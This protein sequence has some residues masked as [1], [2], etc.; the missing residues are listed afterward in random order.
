VDLT[1]IRGRRSSDLTETKEEAMGRKFLASAAIAAATFGVTAGPAL[2]NSVGPSFS[3]GSKLSAQQHSLVNTRM[4]AATTASPAAGS[5]FVVNH[6]KLSEC[7]VPQGGGNYVNFFTKDTTNY[8]EFSDLVLV[9]SCTADLNNKQTSATAGDK[10]D[11]KKLIPFPGTY[12][13][14]SE[15]CNI[16]YK[17]ISFVGDALSVVYPSGQFIETC[18]AP[19][20]L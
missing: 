8:V 15:A 2:A 5:A 3:N 9:G 6:G 11:G 7:T 16:Q 17:G 19:V 10:P 12:A 4:K 13:T 18:I 1:L 14:Y 20:M